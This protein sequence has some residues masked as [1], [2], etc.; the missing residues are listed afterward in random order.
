MPE[1]LPPIEIPP[2]AAGVRDPNNLL[3][4]EA[5]RLPALVRWDNPE[6]HDRKLWVIEEAAR[7]QLAGIEVGD[8]MS[9]SLTNRDDGAVT[10]QETQF[11]LYNAAINQTASV[12]QLMK[13]PEIIVGQLLTNGG[14]GWDPPTVAGITR[15]PGY[16][17]RHAPALSLV[18][19]EWPE[20]PRAKAL[21]AAG[22]PYT[23]YHDLADENA[24]PMDNTTVL[25]ASDGDYVRSFRMVPKAVRP[26][27]SFGGGYTRETFWEMRYKRSP[28]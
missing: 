21:K 28:K 4:D 15:Y 20:H 8:W 2:V 23:V 5:W 7:L 16:K 22:S 11:V 17:A 18:G 9:T 6:L 24:W 25:E 1:K 10:H 27:M 3:N 19:A 12:Y 13:N 26:G 14:N